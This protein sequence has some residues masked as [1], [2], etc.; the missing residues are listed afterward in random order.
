MKSISVFGG[1]IAGMTVAHELSEKGFDVT[2]YEKDEFLGGMAKS[3]RNLDNIPTEHSWR[4]YNT[5]FY[6]NCIDILKRIP[7]KNEYFDEDFNSYTI[8][9]IQKHN[10]EDDL[11]TYYKGNV[12]DITKFV[13]HHPGG[14][15]I[16]NAGGK[17]LEQVWENFNVKWHNK[18][19]EVQS[20]LEKYKIGKIKE[21]F[22]SPK[23]SVFDNLIKGQLNFKFLKNER[24]LNNPSSFQ[25]LKLILIIMQNLCSDKRQTDIYKKILLKEFMKQHFDE[26]TIQ[27][28]LHGFT[29]PGIGLDLNSSSL[30]Q[31]C[32]FASLQHIENWKV[33]NKPTSEAW[34][35]QWKFYLK[36]TKNVKFVRGE[37]KK[38]KTSENNVT[39][40]ELVDGRIVKTNEYCFAINPYNAIQIFEESKI[41][42][43]TIQ[44]QNLMTVNNQISFFITFKKKIKFSS[45][46]NA[47][48]LIDSLYNITLYSQ[49]NIWHENYL[50]DKTKSL[51]SGTC[52]QAQNGIFLSISDFK[53]E[54]IKQIFDCKSFLDLLEKENKFRLIADDIDK[55]EIYDEWKYVNGR[56]EAD[57]KKWV[58]NISND[59]F[60]PLSV[61]DFN[62]LY[63]AG[64]H[65]KTTFP[66]WS[67]ES[68]VESGKI[69][70]NLILDKYSLE[71]TFHYKHDVNILIKILAVFD[72]LFYMI[73]LPNII[74]VLLYLLVLIIVIIAI[75]IKK[76]HRS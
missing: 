65:T 11:W 71:K 7:I 63:I 33:M 37:L 21:N 8:E 44:F 55:M 14:R 66:I 9:E 46:M 29:G 51:W 35:D 1:G 38:I 49:D 48:V 61:T 73:G 27:Y 6:V 60:R 76:I 74:T 22:V 20:N 68:S 64:G 10:K 23:I 28:I 62:N 70:S 54:I 69:T 67:M 50:Q 57:N 36:K 40:C 32:F 31:F 58:N 75:M 16:L 2:V 53:N 56:L 59:E 18:D 15:L 17:S 47:N 24:E 45:N 39:S 43:Y 19:P 12:Y 30:Y 42:K 34:F 4:G 13:K 25:Y 26:E 5:S 3:K 72:N 52:C 41:E